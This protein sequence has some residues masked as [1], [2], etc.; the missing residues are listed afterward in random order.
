[1]DAK[2]C[3]EMRSFVA[4]NLKLAR[5]IIRNEEKGN[6]LILIGERMMS[7]SHRKSECHTPL[8]CYFSKQRHR[9]GSYESPTVEQV[10]LN[11]IYDTTQS[12]YLIAC[13]G[14]IYRPHE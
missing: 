5:D 13:G 14:S 12:I 11:A 4:L 6:G 8:E 1:M 3:A 9:G 2:R 10:P 7:G